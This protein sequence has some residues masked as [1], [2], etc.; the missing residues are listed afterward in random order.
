MVLSVSAHMITFNPKDNFNYISGRTTCLKACENVEGRKTEGQQK[1]GEQ[2]SYR[3][4]AQA[5][6][7]ST[8]A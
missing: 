3:Q 7:P 6:A 2:L 4:P 5:T 8:L 1:D